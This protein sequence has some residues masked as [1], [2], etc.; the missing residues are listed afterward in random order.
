MNVQISDV[1]PLSAELI[2]ATA[3]VLMRQHPYMHTEEIQS[4]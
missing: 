3:S 1:P 4:K 2:R